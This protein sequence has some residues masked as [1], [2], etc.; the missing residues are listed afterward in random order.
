MIFLLTPFSCNF[1]ILGDVPL[2][3]G[4]HFLH[5]VG[6]SC[7]MLFDLPEDCSCLQLT[8]TSSLSKVTNIQCHYTLG[9][10]ITIILNN[11]SSQNIL[12]GVFKVCHLW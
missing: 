2:V 9:A 3:D 6:I 1:S 7:N 10:T 4:L 5:N 8:T 11:K 12:G